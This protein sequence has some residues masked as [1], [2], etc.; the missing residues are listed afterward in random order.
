MQLWTESLPIR[1]V[2]D[3]CGALGRGQIAGKAV[4]LQAAMTPQD[5][6]TT[7]VFRGVGFRQDSEFT[8]GMFRGFVGQNCF[9]VPSFRTNVTTLEVV[10]R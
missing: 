2:A 9:K 8:E 1:F 7:V 5:V 6:G 4:N 3:E 10:E